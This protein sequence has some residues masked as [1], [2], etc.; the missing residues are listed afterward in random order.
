MK[1]PITILLKKI[2]TTLIKCGYKV[3]RYVPVPVRD[4]MKKSQVEQN[5]AQKC[6]VMDP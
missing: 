2:L 3:G 1:V 5:K 6:S 4:N